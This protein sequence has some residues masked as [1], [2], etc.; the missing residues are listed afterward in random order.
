MFKISKLS[1]AGLLIASALFIFSCKKNSDSSTSD[2][3]TGGAQDNATA[4]NTSN[5]V[6]SIG[7]EA[8]DNG[9]SLSNFRTA[10]GDL[11]FTSCASVVRDTVAKTITVTFGNVMCMDGR[12]RSGTLVFNF[13][14]STNGATHYRDPGFSMTVT[15]NNYVVNNN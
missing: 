7:A 11:L 8:A 13:S 12:T 1:I 3:D 6:V 4:E 14:A 15:S 10:P 5:D 2:S 9:G